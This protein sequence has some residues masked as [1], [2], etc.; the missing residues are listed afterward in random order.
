[1]SQHLDGLA[2]GD[3]VEVKGPVGH[4]VYE[5]RGAY[6]LNKKQGA[7]AGGEWRVDGWVESLMKCDA[8][9]LVIDDILCV[10]S[11]CALSLLLPPD[12]NTHCSPR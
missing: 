11:P 2:L 6:S 4:F 5:G 10:L 12:A 8:G 7:C 1:M 3:T 9:L